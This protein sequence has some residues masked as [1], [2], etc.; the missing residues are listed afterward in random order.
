MI[1]GWDYTGPRLFYVDSDGSR[2]EGDKFSVGSG[3]TFAYG[4]LDSVEIHNMNVEEAIDI[5]RRSIFHAT[6]RD[7]YSGGS[8]NGTSRFFNC[9]VRYPRKWLEVCK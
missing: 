5:A 3:S 4:V 1:A 9:S 6:H 8:V 7:A 2:L